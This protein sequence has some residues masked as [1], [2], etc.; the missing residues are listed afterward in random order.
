[1]ILIAIISLFVMP[2]PMTPFK[3]DQ[4]SAMVRV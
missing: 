4:P 2:C 1:M 3:H